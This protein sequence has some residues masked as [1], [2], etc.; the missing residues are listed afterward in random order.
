[1]AVQVNLHCLALGAESDDLNCG[2]E[3]VSSENQ[4]Q[5]LCVFVEIIVSGID[6]TLLAQSFILGVLQDVSAE[7]NDCLVLLVE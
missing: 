3:E 2:L 7:V 1:V 4:I 6:F 5:F